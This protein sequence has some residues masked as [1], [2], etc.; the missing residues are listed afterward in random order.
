MPALI[1]IAANLILGGAVAW[2]LRGS[3]AI[4]REVMSWALLALVGFEALI[5]T[6]VATYLFRFYPQW[7]MLYVFDPQI[8]PALESWIGVLS[9]LEVL[10]NFAAAVGAFCATREGLLRGKRWLTYAAPGLGAGLALVLFMAY[11]E[12]I[13]FMGDYDTFWQGNADLFLVRLGGWVGLTLYAGA[14]FFIVFLHRRFADH[15]PKLV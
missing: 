1:N 15:D 8:F 10:L 6:P 13:V 7:S 4:R 9:F 14:V 2:V 5:F 3:S 11:G 12:R